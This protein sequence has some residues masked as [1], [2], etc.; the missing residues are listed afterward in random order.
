MKILLME[1]DV[2]LGETIQELLIDANYECDWVMDGEAAAEASYISK[3]DLYIFDI[4]VP[5]ING[6][7]LLQ[8][9][10][11]AEDTT[12]TIFISAMTDIAA[13]TKGFSVG[14]DDYLKKPFYPEELLLR[15]EAR[16]PRHL[17]QITYGEI[18]YNGLTKE[19]TKNGHVVSLG[20][21][22]LPFLELFITNIGRTLSKESLMEMMEHPSDN[23]LRVAINK[24]KQTTGWKIEN[25][26]AIGYRI[27]K[28]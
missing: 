12:A 25:V 8:S 24:L 7:D 19:V 1:D 14:A 18:T 23:A 26:R 20:D 16:L 21:V 27:E 3:Y 9:L 13:L 11:N 5:E 2:V 22:Q 15:I 17:K 28:S 4:N 10:R 6:F